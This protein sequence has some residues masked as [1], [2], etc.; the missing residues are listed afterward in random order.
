[1]DLGDRTHSQGDSII[2][3]QVK[4]IFEE[5]R[6]IQE[7]FF[8]H[9]TGDLVR[10][11]GR[12]ADT[13][14]QGGRLLTLGTGT[15]GHVA[16]ILANALTHRIVVN[17]PPLPALALSCDTSLLGHL[18]ERTSAGEMFTRQ[19]E[20]LGRKGDLVI[21]FSWDGDSPAALGA[22]VRARESGLETGA[23]LG[24]DGGK[25]KNY[26]ELAL[27]VEAETPARIHEVH[28]MAAQILAQLVE[29]H[30]FPL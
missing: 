26:T 4:E 16:R 17:R 18:A 11:A 28:L 13:F 3:N 12:V 6:F 22:L 2:D 30:L 27:V 21:A 7:R 19:V 24:R 5:L 14:R 9:C 15:S 20:A 29:R 25:I 8:T 10:L 23:F 1:M